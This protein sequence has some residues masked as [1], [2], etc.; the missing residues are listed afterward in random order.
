[1]PERNQAQ[2]SQLVEIILAS[3]KYRHISAD[4]VKRI[5]AAELEKGRKPKEAV[6]AAKKKLHQIAGAYLAEK[7]V[8][9]AWLQTLKASIQSENPQDLKN[10]CREILQQHA[11][12]RE[13]LPILHDF[14]TNI[15]DEVG[16]IHSVLD[17]ACGFNPLTIPWM[18]LQNEF[19][20]YACDIYDD[21][22]GFLNSFIKLYQ[23]KGEAWVCDVI[24]QA[25]KQEVD[26]ALLLKAIPCLEQ[27][28]KSVGERLLDSVNARRLI[29]S[30]PIHSLGGKQKG[31]PK[32]YEARFYSLVEGKSWQIKRF[33]FDTELAF[34]ITK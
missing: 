13:R 11:S 7:P 22:A 1:M 20:Y 3:Q 26:L 23:A 30:F 2:L 4:L 5:G 33:E 8:Y 18:P 32:N 31:M 24:Y 16:P 34:L 28:D 21:L 19:T 14:Y 25:P 17:I 10:A 29:V 12:T 9:P 27:I 15:L 6:K